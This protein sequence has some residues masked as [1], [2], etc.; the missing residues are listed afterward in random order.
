MCV[1]VWGGPVP[2]TREDSFKNTVLPGAFYSKS[3]KKWVFEE[4]G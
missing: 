3:V 1:C 4:T 2:P